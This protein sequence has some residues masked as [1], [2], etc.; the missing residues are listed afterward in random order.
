MELFLGVNLIW[1]ANNRI[2]E[3][4]LELLQLPSLELWKW[5]RAQDDW[6]SLADAPQTPPVT[7][8]GLHAEEFG[9]RFMTS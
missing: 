8:V 3:Y 5:T 1:T 6:V 4:H 2:K 7:T 9:R